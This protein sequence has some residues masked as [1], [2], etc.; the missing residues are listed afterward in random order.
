MHVL[1]DWVNAYQQNR[2]SATAELLTLLTQ[3]PSYNYHLAPVM[4]PSRQH[5]HCLAELSTKP[6]SMSV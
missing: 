1:Q 3:V 6:T 2:A 5:V 4:W